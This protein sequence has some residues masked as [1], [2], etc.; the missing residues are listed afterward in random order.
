MHNIGNLIRERRIALGLTQ[1]ELASRVGYKSG[2]SITRLENERDI[3]ISKLKPIADAL[4]IDIRVLVGWD[5]ET[6]TEELIED[7]Y[8]LSD[9]NKR[10]LKRFLAYLVG[11]QGTQKKDKEK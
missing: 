9:E 11:L 6:S 5:N 10:A 2:T 3:P 7:Y 1:D 4:D 8:K